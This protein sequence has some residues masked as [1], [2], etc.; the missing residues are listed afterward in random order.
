[1]EARALEHRQRVLCVL[2]WGAGL[3]DSLDCL[4]DVHVVPRDFCEGHPEIQSREEAGEV[5][6]VLHTCPRLRFGGQ[7]DPMVAVE[8][9][10]RHAAGPI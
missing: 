7:N 6:I 9:A 1:M 3:D 4:V 8:E 2:A 5:L 10:A